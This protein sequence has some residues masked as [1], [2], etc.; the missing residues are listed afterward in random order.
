MELQ[1]IKEKLFY[2]E[3]YNFLRSDPKLGG[4]IILLGL[5]GRGVCY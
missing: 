1:Q 4:N 5:G 3:E 2:G